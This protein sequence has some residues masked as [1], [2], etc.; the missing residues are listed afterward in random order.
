MKNL[1]ILFLA[2]FVFSG[3]TDEQND[4]SKLD[5]KGNIKKVTTIRYRAVEKFGNV[6]KGKKA[7]R[8]ESQY[9]D[10]TYE[11]AMVKFDKENKITDVSAFDKY[12]DLEWKAIFKNDTIIDIVQP[13]GE[14]YYKFIGNDRWAPTKMDIYGSDGKMQ[15]RATS[16]YENGK[17]MKSDI[18]N[19]EGKLVF[20]QEFTYDKKGLMIQFVSSANDVSGYRSRDK[21]EVTTELMEYNEAGI[22]VAQTTENRGNSERIDFKYK[23]DENGN[24]IERI[25]YIS[26]IPKYLIERTIEYH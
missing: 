19:R 17:E 23:F 5:L 11:N 13:N 10:L 7:S 22:M 20:H 1:F 3:C 6:E 16:I 15:F 4:L 18:Y 12:G 14:L 24:W 26:S 2:I 8:K 21:T 25:E 9:P